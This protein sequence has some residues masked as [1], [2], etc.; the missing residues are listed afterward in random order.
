MGLERYITYVLLATAIRLVLHQQFLPART[1]LTVFIIDDGI[2]QS[3]APWCWSDRGLA[4]GIDK[5][6]PAREM[7]ERF[8][9]KRID[10]V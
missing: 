2:L 9:S 7:L 10:L 6:K 4:C 5:N 8:T 3:S 1:L